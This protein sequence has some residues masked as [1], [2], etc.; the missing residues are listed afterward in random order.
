MIWGKVRL[1][2][3]SMRKICPF[4]DMFHIYKKMLENIWVQPELFRTFLAPLMHQFYP[5]TPVRKKPRLKQIEITLTCCHLVY[6]TVRDQ[7]LQT[8]DLID[9]AMIKT[10]LRNIIFL[11]E[12][13]IPIVSSIYLLLI[14]LV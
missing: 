10:H 6:P 1:F 14:L 3:P 2:G 11:F 9:N 13:L 8:L 12:F 7:I 4:L 5:K